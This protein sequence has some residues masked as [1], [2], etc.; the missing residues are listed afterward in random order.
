MIKKERFITILKKFDKIKPILVIGDIGVDKYTYGEVKRIS[1]EA[2]IPVLEVKKEFFKLGLAA[3]VVDNLKSLYV[4]STI[5]GVIGDDKNADLIE[6]LFKKN[7]IKTC[8]LIKDK[9]RITTFKERITTET[10]QICRID[11]ETK[12]H[13]DN[14]VFE[15]TKIFFDESKNEHSAFM[16]QDYGKGFLTKNII[17]HTIKEAKNLKKI[18]AIDPSIK[19]CPDYYKG[20]TLLKPNRNEAQ[21]MVKALGYNKTYSLEEIAEILVDKLCLEKIIITVGSDGMAMI[22]T[23]DDGYFFSIP[24]VAK[25][26]FDVSGAG[27]TAISGILASM[28]SG[29]SLKEAAWIGNCAAGVVVGKKGTALVTSQ[30]LIDFHENVEKK[31]TIN[32]N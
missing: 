2:P 22:D 31:W 9:D 20:A 25:E 26:V 15:K 10:Q 6:S 27:D 24:T 3:N 12:K 1:P 7:N 30:E 29:A 17:Q 28:V 19:T 5:C 4:D 32:I 11:Y 16:I 14:I 21:L 8:G 18:I 23:T 13:V